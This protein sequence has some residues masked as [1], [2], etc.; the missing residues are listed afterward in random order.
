MGF[1][2]INFYHDIS[3]THKIKMNLFEQ[4]N[5]PLDCIENKRLTKT[6]FCVGQSG[7][8]WNAFMTVCASTITFQTRVAIMKFIYTISSCWHVLFISKDFW[9]Y[10]RR[11]Y[12]AHPVSAHCSVD[13]AGKL[14]NV[15]KII[16]YKVKHDCQMQYK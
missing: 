10:V 4:E 6:L 11:L 9:G 2:I 5:R 8:K 1:A 16:K 14:P 7:T 12:T 13:L 15:I 3:D